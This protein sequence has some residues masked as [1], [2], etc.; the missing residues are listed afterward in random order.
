MAAVVTQFPDDDEAKT[1]YALSL[2]GQMPVGDAALPLRRQAGALLEGVFARNP[3]HPGAAHYIIH[4]YDHGDLA[5]R[6]LPAARMYA[7]I[8]PAASHALHMPAHT[9]LQLG[10]WSEAAATDQNSWDASVAWA[11][12]RGASPALYDFHS[13][14][15]LQYEWTQMGKFAAAAGAMARVDEGLKVIKASDEVGGHHYG[16]SAIGRGSGPSTLR[17]DRGAMRARYIV[18]SERWPEM[19]GQANFDNVDELFALGL[20]SVRMKDIPRAEAALDQLRRAS[21]PEQ[22]PELREQAAVMTREMDALLLIATGQQELGFQAMQQA[23]R[24]QNRMPRPIG[25]PY[26]VKGADE[27]FG[28]ALLEA[29]RA[30]E[31]RAWFEAALKRTPNRSRAVLGLARAAARLGD[32]AGSRKAYT[33]F[34]D[35]WKA[36]DAGLPEVAEARKA[37]GKP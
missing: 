27:L 29:G 22:Q 26:P 4:A 25:R 36:A 30:T 33:Q 18:E 24:L 7:S 37:L 28:E 1:F 11:K 23:V 8:A 34:L 12:Q 13:L 35:N 19:R 15:W 17:N 10:L 16:D 9:F 31:A 2:L 6:A 32:S 14:S 21:G 20:A 3:K 5:A